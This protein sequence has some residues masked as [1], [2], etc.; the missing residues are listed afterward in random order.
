MKQPGEKAGIVGLS[1]GRLVQRGL[2]FRM[3]SS[4]PASFQRAVTRMVVVEVEVPRHGLRAGASM[5]RM[6]IAYSVP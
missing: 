3:A 2:N 5:D 4:L 1:S 6:V